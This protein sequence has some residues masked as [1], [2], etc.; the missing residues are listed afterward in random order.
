MRGRGFVAWALAA[1]VGAGAAG[2]AGCADP[3]RPEAV[4]L[5]RPVTDRTYLRDGHG[6]YLTVHGVNLGGSTK[7]PMT[8][9]GRPIGP[10]QMAEVNATGVPSYLGRPFVLART[11]GAGETGTADDPCCPTG[12]DGKADDACVHA[13][14]DREMKDIAD[15]GFN[16][17][18][19]L[20]NWEGAEPTGRGKYDD[21]YIA[22]VRKAVEAANRHG[23]YVLVDMH[24]DSFSRHLV[25]QYNEYPEAAW[26]GAQDDA[27]AR[28]ILSLL[29][30]PDGKYTDAVRGEGAPRWIVEQCLQEKDLD[31]PHWGRPRLL[32]GLSKTDPGTADFLVKL[33][34]LLG[35]LLGGG[36]GAPAIPPWVA[37]LLDHLPEGSPPVWETVDPLPF[38]NWGL[39]SMTSVD[40]ARAFGCLMALD[41]VRK[42]NPGWPRMRALECR[43]GRHR[44]TDFRRCDAGK[45]EVVKKCDDPG[46]SDAYPYK[47]DGCA[48]VREISATEWVQDAYAT[49]WNR[50][51]REVADLPNVIGYDIINE[52][53]GN[54]IVLTADAAVHALGVV[55]AAKTTLHDLLG[56]ENGDLVFE[57]LTTLRLIPDFA[58]PVGP[59]SPDPCGRMDKA[60]RVAKCKAPPALGTDCDSLDDAALL[61]RCIAID[62]GLDKLDFMAV[63]GFNVG[64]DRN[65]LKPFYEKVGGAIL[66]ADA[67]AVLWLEP[68]MNISMLI[69]GIGG[70]WDVGMTR[71]ENLPHVVW[72]PHF[73]ADIYPFPGFN[74][75]MRDFAVEEVRYRDYDAGLAGAATLAT[76][77]LGNPPVVFGEFGT[78]YSFGGHEKSAA[79]GYAV[80]Q[81]ILDN[82]YEALDRLGLGRIV[83]CY[84]SDNDAHYGDLWNKE[85]F[86]IRGPAI[87][88]ANGRLV[89][90]GPWRAERGWARP[91]ARAV[92]GKPI[93]QR[94]WS[95]LHWFDPSSGQVPP[96][97]EYELTYER[98]ET[99][100]PT[101]IGIPSPRNGE[102]VTDAGGVH[103]PAWEPYPDGFY[104]WLSD[105]WAAY[106]PDRRI[107]YHWPSED[108]PGTLHT[109]RI[110]PPLPR[111]EA[112]GWRYFF[113]GGHVVVGG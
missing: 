57:L 34:N 19:M 56:A 21:A 87:R 72:A 22:S 77:N 105:G 86:S 76:W 50:V 82:Y 23:V 107:L 75:R 45:V 48:K 95:P 13:A 66:A 94:Y 58:P 108:E 36:G 110:R 81:H 6:R 99:G 30:G 106:D 101:E 112:T 84:T 9:D 113:K 69:G 78:Y 37:Y 25:S 40:T 67:D 71:P 98:K 88:A 53:N 4:P 96:A 28:T 16:V 63:A 10:G 55:D 79:A 64:F 43:D 17:V 24:Q 83:W 33:G 35:K 14:A 5:T 70:M 12:P 93:S 44:P 85:D 15:A 46:A 89:D 31:S 2:A 38:T 39:M 42:L 60:A 97:G 102:R 109:V 111:D 92:A 26:P 100:A 1:A 18:R 11:C 20:V 41:P 91:N 74:V 8:V 27:I 52:P 90:P 104:V 59:D 32:S 51:A 3:G 68:T 54:F 73:Y 103:V 65:F 29:P 61:K 62:W 47:L 80:S 7:V 49:M